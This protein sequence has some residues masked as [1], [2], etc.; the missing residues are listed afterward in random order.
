MIFFGVSSEFIYFYYFIFIVQLVLV[1]N[2]ILSKN[3]PKFVKI[4]EI[5][6]L[7][8]F[9][10][11]VFFLISILPISD[12]DS[13]AIHLNI[14][15][16]F[17]FKGFLDDNYYQNIEKTLFSGTEVVLFLSFVL[18]SDN[19]GSQLNFFTLLIFFYS[20]RFNRNFLIL[21]ISSPLIIFFISTQKLQLFYGL[22]Y[23]YLFIQIYK[24]NFLYKDDIFIFI[25]L[26]FFYASGKLSYILFGVL[27][28]LYFLFKNYK[29]LKFK[30]VIN[31][32]ILNFF[33]IFF[34][35]L[36]I[37]YNYFNNPVAPFADFFFLK[38]D[39]FYAFANDIRSSSGWINNDINLNLFLKSFI[40]LNISSIS[41]YY[42]I[43][44]L[45]MFFNYRHQKNLNFVPLLI[46]TLVII[47]GQLLPRYYLEAFLILSFFY[48]NKLTK[49]FRYICYFQMF[50][51]III[52]L[53]FVFI[54][55]KLIILDN[56]KKSSFSEKFVHQFYN[57]NTYNLELPKNSNILL[58]TADR[59]HIFFKK[60]YYSY[61]YLNILNRYNNNNIKNLS[62]FI[63]DNKIKYFVYPSNFLFPECIKIKN[64]KKILLSNAQRNFFVDTIQSGSYIGKLIKNDCK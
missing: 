56:W 21:I 1:L 32:G 19:F 47:N 11:F 39:A 59:D 35:I 24:K 10:L 16:E 13:L 58:I 18:K 38:R 5:G 8:Y 22:I 17:F 50:T 23:L 54:S 60:N 44:F 57:I 2:L 34:P 36:L 3:F 15:K 37:K 9:L 26:L 29:N 30:Y 42:G 52:S 33:L 55:Y 62:K 25:Y 46:F 27:L 64:E 20:Y 61:R 41:A 28:F 12:A 43:L 4:L 7:F 63:N 53:S 45:I 14:P 6:K 31:S 40:P 49:I 48:G 51:I